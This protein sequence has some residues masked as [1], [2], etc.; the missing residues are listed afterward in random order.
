MQ[1]M[2]AVKDKGYD[3][4]A[5]GIFDRKAVLELLEVDAE[6]YVPVMLLAVGKAA[7]TALPSVRLLLEYTV[8]WNNGLG[9]KK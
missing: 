6:R 4:H 9:F 5:I 3:S 2:L 1:W 8:S 7:T